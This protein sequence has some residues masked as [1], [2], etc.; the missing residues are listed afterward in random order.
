[1]VLGATAVAVGTAMP[2][3]ATGDVAV[4]RAYDVSGHQL[5]WRDFRARQENGR[6]SVG[7]NDVLVDP[8]T[9]SPLV[10]GPLHRVG[11]DPAVEW[12]GRPATLAMAW[13]AAHG[14]DQLLL[15]LPGPGRHL[16]DV[17]AA[18]QAVD[19]LE[20][21]RR[22]HPVRSARVRAL[23]ASARREL[24][25]AEGHGSEARRGAAGARSFRAAQAAM[26]ELLVAAG[27]GRGRG[28]QW[29]VTFD[30]LAGDDAFAS[31][32]GLF[33]RDGWVRLVVDR[34]VPPSAYRAA[35][36]RAHRAG[37]RVTCELVD[38]SEMASMSEGRF[39]ARVETFVRELP[40]VDAWE[41]GNEVNLRGLGTDGADRVKFAAAHVKAHTSARTLLTLAWQAGEDD[42][43]YSTFGWLD[44]HPDALAD[45]DDVGL[46]IYPDQN[47]LGAAFGRVMT[48]LH[49]RL[50]GKRIL[51]TELGYATPDGEPIWWWGSRR[52]PRG[53]ARRAVARFYQSAVMAFPFSGGGAYWWYFLDEARRGDALWRTLRAARLGG[54]RS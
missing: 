23:A 41:V 29:G 11:D 34:D 43:R 44:A 25:R 3:V 50:P 18:R 20:R 24:A 14:Y 54:A 35:V 26:V 31:V 15:D 51:V 30:R 38:S 28:L 12:P 9:L 32:S 42:A 19:A 53:A 21:A 52:D 46:S 16:F 5:S 47:P 13:P 4:L 40:D 10:P 1:M 7:A 22:E 2:D 49:R 6:G 37:L 39:R 33:G 36:E 8:Q 27:R 45:I 48:T 17:L